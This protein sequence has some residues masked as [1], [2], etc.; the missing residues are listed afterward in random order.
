MIPKSVADIDTYA[1]SENEDLLSITV[2]TV[3]PDN[4]A[5]CDID[6]VLYSKDKTVP[7]HYSH[8]RKDAEFVIAN[9]VME[10]GAAAFENCKN[11]SSVVL[12]DNLTTIGYCAFQACG[13][14]DI[15]FPNSLASIGRFAFAHCDGLTSVFI[16]NGVTEFWPR[17]FVSC[18][19]LKFVSIPHS[20]TTIYSTAFGDCFSLTSV[21]IPD[22]VTEIADDAF[23]NCNYLTIVTT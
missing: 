7:V 3:D 20:L 9:H 14:T 2:D 5:Y 11:L 15:D 8:G 19:N 16:P 18:E 1:F 22:S 17:A 4:P 6:S 23:E 13:L 10:I 21:A 12:P